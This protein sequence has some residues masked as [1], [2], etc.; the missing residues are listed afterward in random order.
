MGA[1]KDGRRLVM[2]DAPTPA[3]A[4]VGT[5]FGYKPEDRAWQAKRLTQ[6]LDKVRDIRRMGSAAIDLANVA[7]GVLDGYFETGLNPWDLA[8][9]ELLV[10]EAGGKVV[11]IDGGKPGY[12]LTVAG[13]AALADWLVQAVRY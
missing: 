5:G 7:D 12:D 9:G 10:R 1:F 2:A 13:P 6:V 11:G 8:A 3:M 4:L